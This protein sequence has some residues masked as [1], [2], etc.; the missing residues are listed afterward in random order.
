MH[1][2]QPNT[3][4]QANRNNVIICGI[5]DKAP[6]KK[7]LFTQSIYSYLNQ[8]EDEDAEVRG[9]LEL[10]ELAALLVIWGPDSIKM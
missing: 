2:I 6:Q 1:S 9:Q 5:K 4:P 8:Q 7:Q 10:N 3:G